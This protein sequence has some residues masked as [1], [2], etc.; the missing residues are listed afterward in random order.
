MSY[1]WKNAFFPIYCATQLELLPQKWMVLVNFMQLQ[2]E[3]LKKKWS[4]ARVVWQNRILLNFTIL[5]RIKVNES[6]RIQ[7]MLRVFADPESNERTKLRIFWWM[8]PNS[9]EFVDYLRILMNSN[10]NFL[11]AP[12]S[13]EWILFNSNELQNACGKASFPKYPPIPKN[14]N[15]R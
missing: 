9:N 4:G 3:I 6:K 15:A 13:E 2:I 7:S 1:R 5:N 8:T 11:D 10:K 12:R 14:Y